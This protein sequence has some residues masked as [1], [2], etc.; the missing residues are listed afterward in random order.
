MEGHLDLDAA[1][2]C[3]RHGRLEAL[4]RAGF[5]EAQGRAQHS[6]SRRLWETNRDQVGGFV[7]AKTDESERDQE[8]EKGLADGKG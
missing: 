6:T 5:H 4:Q 7:S 3:F 8:R 1:L 2:L